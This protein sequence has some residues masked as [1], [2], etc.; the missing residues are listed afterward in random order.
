MILNYWPTPIMF[1]SIEDN[2]LLDKTTEYILSSYNDKTNANVLHENILDD[3]QLT[4]FKKKVIIPA[5]D[6]FYKQEFGF[7]VKDKKFHLRGWI[8]GY[9]VS[10]AMPKHNHSGSHLSA[11]FYLLAEEKDKGGRL[12]LSD[13]R[14]NANRG[15]KDEY[16][17]W[18]E[19][20]TKIP[21]TG[22]IIL[23][24][25]FL[26]HNVETFYGKLRLAMPVDLILYDSE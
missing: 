25:S 17:K 22:D 9:G 26:Y 14:F 5:F 15:Y 12:I 1:D 16:L 13:P 11:I 7:S 6:K 19:T 8:T 2:K 21:A 23:F 18:F 20:E 24:P 10:Y 4:D 3:K